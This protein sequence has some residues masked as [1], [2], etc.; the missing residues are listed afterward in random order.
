MFEYSK[1]LE[2]DIKILFSSLKCLA[3]FIKQYPLRE[4]P[5]RQFP[6]ILGVGSYVWNLLQAISE[7]EWDHFKVS[8][9]SNTLTL[10]EAMRTV[11]S[12]NL[13]PT[14]SLNIEIVVDICQ[15][16]F[17][18]EWKSAEWIWKWADLWNDLGFSLCST[19]SVC[20]IVATSDN[21]KKSEMEV[22]AD[23]CVAIEHQRLS[24]IRDYLH[25]LS[26]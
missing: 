6:T 5:I 26:D 13:I 8:P 1:H 16:W 15:A 23:W 10:V 19:L 11:Y 17:T 25:W 14:P 18:L 7:S 2:T 21:R 9:Q 22:S 12:P 4:H 20:C 24:S 3:C